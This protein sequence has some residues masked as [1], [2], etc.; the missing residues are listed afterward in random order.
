M[1]DK[2]LVWLGSSRSDLRAFPDN[3]RRVAGFQLR[4]VQRGLEPNDWKPMPAV[5]PGVREIRIHTELEQRV[6]YV[7]RFTEGVYVLHVFEKR[8]R[9][10]PKREVELAR[11]RFR[12]L[13]LKRKT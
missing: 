11:D 6:F 7:A 5:G 13:L 10:T 1:P 2:P 4:R 3:A 12:N 8:T 9:K